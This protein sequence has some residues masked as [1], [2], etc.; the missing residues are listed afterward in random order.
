MSNKFS[1]ESQYISNTFTRESPRFQTGFHVSQRSPRHSNQLYGKIV[2]SRDPSIFSLISFVGGRMHTYWRYVRTS[3]RHESLRWYVYAN[4][5][6]CI[7]EWG[8][9]F[10]SWI[11]TIICVCK[12]IVLHIWMCVHS[13]THEN[14]TYMFCQCTYKKVANH[15]CAFEMRRVAQMNESHTWIMSRIVASRICVTNHV[16][17]HCVANV[18]VCVS[19]C[20]VSHKWMSRLRE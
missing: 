4:A 5:L 9:V 3:L 12:C 19:E 1:Q 14:V 18:I 16:A 10:A 20:V 6:C 7:Y 2:K 11:I 15:V 17:N 8:G 13:P